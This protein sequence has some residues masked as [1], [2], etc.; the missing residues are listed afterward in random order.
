MRRGRAA[1]LPPSPPAPRGGGVPGPSGVHAIT[2][3][4]AEGAGGPASRRVPPR[5]CP[6]LRGWV[7]SLGFAVG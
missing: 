5:A 4:H 7:G 6:E 1:S 3:P 2:A